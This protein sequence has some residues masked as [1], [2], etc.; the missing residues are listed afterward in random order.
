MFDNFYQISHRLASCKKMKKAHLIIIAEA[1]SFNAQ[2]KHL[3]KSQSTMAQEIGVTRKTINATIKELVDLGILVILRKVH[4]ETLVLCI[5]KPNLMAYIDKNE[6]K[7]KRDE[8]NKL[9]DSGDNSLIDNGWGEPSDTL[10]I[11]QKINNLDGEKKLHTT[12]EKITHKK[13]N[14][15]NNKYTE[16]FSEEN[17]RVSIDSLEGYEYCKEAYRFL[18]LCK[19]KAENLYTGPLTLEQWNQ[20]EEKLSEVLSEPEEVDTLI[21]NIHRER[22][23]HALKSV[24]LPYILM[25]FTDC[26]EFAHIAMNCTEWLEE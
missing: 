23:M 21:Y 6:H 16:Q 10:S 18:N 7:V 11:K 2:G 12:C 15:N 3:W 8:F 19:P 26:E 20:C 1:C 5:N 4:N 22:K 13:N 25:A 24:S 17:R 14:D 9:K